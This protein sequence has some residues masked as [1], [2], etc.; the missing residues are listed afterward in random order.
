MLITVTA[1]PVL[2]WRTGPEVGI[3][4]RAGATATCAAVE[5]LATAVAEIEPEP[6]T[7]IPAEA[8]PEPEINTINNVEP[9]W[10]ENQETSVHV[11]YTNE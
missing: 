10:Q 7:V 1:V 3:T 11:V 9:T 5:P 4:R 8:T 2:L 6:R